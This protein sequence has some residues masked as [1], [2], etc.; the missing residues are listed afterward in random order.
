[1][2][3]LLFKI[4]SF[5]RSDSFTK[6]LYQKTYNFTQYER[7]SLVVIVLMSMAVFLGKKLPIGIAFTELTIFG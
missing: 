3:V 7:R 5:A 4:L 1:M 2:K 6:F